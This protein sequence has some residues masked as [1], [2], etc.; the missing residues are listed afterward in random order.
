MDLERRLSEIRR[1]PQREVQPTQIPVDSRASRAG[2]RPGFHNDARQLHHFTERGFLVLR[3]ATHDHRK[4]DEKNWPAWAYQRYRRRGDILNRAANQRWLY[5]DTRY[6]GISSVR[7]PEHLPII[8]KI[9]AA[10][11]PKFKQKFEK[12]LGM[13]CSD[14][15][16]KHK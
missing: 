13:S 11:S 15:L 10:K 1:C 7:R 6:R 4:T 16:K 5:S 2:G 14:L 12:N 3:R 9:W 8:Q